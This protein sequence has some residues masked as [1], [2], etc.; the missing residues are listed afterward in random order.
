MPL[1]PWPVY[2][3][4]LMWFGILLSTGR[5]LILGGLTVILMGTI[6]Y[7]I[8]SRV[9]KEWPFKHQVQDRAKN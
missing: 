4:I 3:A 8:K 6:V 5:L 7:L 2:L 9:Q 1:F